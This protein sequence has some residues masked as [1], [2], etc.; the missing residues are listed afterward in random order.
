[1]TLLSERLQQTDMAGLSNAEAATALNSPRPSWAEANGV[2]VDA[3][4]VAAARAGARTV[5]ILEWIGNGAAP[6]G[7]VYEQ[8]RLL[9]SG[10]A[11]VAPIFKLPMA[12]N[13]MLRTAALNNWLI[14]NDN[15]LS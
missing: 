10:G 3:L 13:A 15:L 2:T 7:G 14:S 5:T 12:G 4:A 6:G 1:M 11:E 9:L 8:V